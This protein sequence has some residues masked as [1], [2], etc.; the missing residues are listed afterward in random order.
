M[1]KKEKEVDC[2]CCGGTGK[3]KLCSIC[4]NTGTVTNTEVQTVGKMEGTIYTSKR[5]PNGCVGYT[6]RYAQW[7]EG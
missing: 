2:K 4:N 7:K 1:G 5:C 6:A 3:V